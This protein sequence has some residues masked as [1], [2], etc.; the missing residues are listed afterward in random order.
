MWGGISLVVLVCF[1]LISDFSAPFHVLFGS[2]FLEKCLLIS[3]AHF[4]IEFFVVLYK[5]LPLKAQELD[6]YI[7]EKSILKD[8]FESLHKIFAFW[9]S[10]K[11]WF[12]SGF[13]IIFLIFFLWYPYIYRLVFIDLFLYLTIGFRYYKISPNLFLIYLFT[14][15]FWFNSVK[16]LYTL[17]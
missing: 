13:H 11:F 2:L 5:I 7:F 6:R 17:L 4:W 10:R 14:I 1:F 9:L 15:C 3:S 12:F 16:L 8:Y